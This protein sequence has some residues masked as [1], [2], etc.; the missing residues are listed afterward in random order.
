[1]DKSGKE[2]VQETRSC[3]P[4]SASAEVTSAEELPEPKRPWWY[5][6]KEPGSALQI[7]TAAALAIAI[8]M[9]VTSTVDKV[10]ASAQAILGIPGILW[11]RSLRAVGKYAFLHLELISDEK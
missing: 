7:V 5:S 8:G 4:P 6:I 2:D 3:T 11:L 1:M 10:P 9:T